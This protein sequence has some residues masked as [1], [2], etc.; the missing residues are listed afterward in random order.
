MRSRWMLCAVVGLASAMYA[1][2]S[3][4]YQTAKIVQM[5]SVNCATSEKAASGSAAE[6]LGNDSGNNKKTHEIL[7]QEYVLQTERVIYRVRS[8]DEK[9]SA[10]L[11]LGEA[12]RFRL[13]KD[14]MLLL[15]EYLDG[16]EREYKVVSMTPLSDG[17]TADVALPRLNHLQ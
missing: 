8:R 9:R 11:P 14:K 6:M 16:K 3:K 1:R 2:E 5:D 15:V 10:L 12:A 13:Q 17:S 7:C 4:V